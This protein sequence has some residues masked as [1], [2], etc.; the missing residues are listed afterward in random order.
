MQI[1]WDQNVPYILVIGHVLGHQEISIKRH[2]E[3]TPKNWKIQM[4]QQLIGDK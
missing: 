2:T 1:G 3:G 4:Q